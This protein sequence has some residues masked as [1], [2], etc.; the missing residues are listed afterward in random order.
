M[1]RYRVERNAACPN[2][3]VVLREGQTWLQIRL[4]GPW[5]LWLDRPLHRLMPMVRAHQVGPL[6]VRVWTERA[7]EM[8]A[9][10][11]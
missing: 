7:R 8:S 2:W 10:R 9:G 6:E 4:G 1:S 3:F 5:G 11:D